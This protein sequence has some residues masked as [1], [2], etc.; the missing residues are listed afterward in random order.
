MA[1]DGGRSRA[2]S[3]CEQPGAG[4][5]NGR[6]SAR[7]DLRRLVGRTDR[8]DRRAIGPGRH[9]YCTVQLDQY[10]ARRGIASLV[11]GVAIRILDWEIASAS[12]S[13][14]RGQYV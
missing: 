5:G 12:W 10:S 13:E 3:L 7:P 8:G 9:G 1:V 2:T 4:R 6:P 11:L 14:R